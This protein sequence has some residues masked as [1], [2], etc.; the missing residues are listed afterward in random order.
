MNG[1]EESKVFFQDKTEAK[2][3]NMNLCRNADF[4]RAVSSTFSWKKISCKG[5]FQ[6]C[7]IFLGTDIPKCEK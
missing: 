2:P 1:R 4:F 6:G 3:D 5:T 7:Q